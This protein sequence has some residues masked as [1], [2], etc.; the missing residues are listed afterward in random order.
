MTFN[1]R[2]E[3]NELLEDGKLDEQIIAD[4]ETCLENLREYRLRCQRDCKHRPDNHKERMAE[5][6]SKIKY[7]QRV[8]ELVKHK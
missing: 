2:Y 7:V 8:L 1:L 4:F 5:A 3:N 6:E